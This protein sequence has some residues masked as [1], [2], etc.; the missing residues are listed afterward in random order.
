MNRLDSCFSDDIK[1]SDMLEFATGNDEIDY[2]IETNN[3]VTEYKES[4]KLHLFEN[5][6]KDADR[7]QII[8]SINDEDMINFL[9]DDLND[10]EEL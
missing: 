10:E 6:K 8:S 9:M 5:A 7:K 4:T 3:I 1:S 2:F